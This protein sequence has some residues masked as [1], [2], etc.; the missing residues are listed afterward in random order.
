MVDLNDNI[1]SDDF[2]LSY[3]LSSFLL[4]CERYSTGLFFLCTT[5]KSYFVD[6]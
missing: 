4:L 1:I 3:L 5:S 2:E 6:I